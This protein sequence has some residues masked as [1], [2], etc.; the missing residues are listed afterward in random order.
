MDFFNMNFSELFKKKHGKN[1][2]NDIC[3]QIILENLDS[4]NEH[5]I[6][7][8]FKVAFFDFFGLNEFVIKNLI[9]DTMFIQNFNFK[10]IKII[11]KNSIKRIQKH[12]KS[13]LS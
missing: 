13:S 7:L 11:H 8:V 10:E 3:K 6:E 1:L 5:Y 2:F 12:L 4:S 9:R